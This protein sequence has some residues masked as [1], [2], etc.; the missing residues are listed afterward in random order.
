MIVD[1]D[2]LTSIHHNSFGQAGKTRQ[3]VVVINQIQLI[4]S[5]FGPVTF[6]NAL[7]I[8]TCHLEIN[9]AT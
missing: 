1:G 6:S 2:P 3:Y 8:E 9:R 7:I 5:T 4:S